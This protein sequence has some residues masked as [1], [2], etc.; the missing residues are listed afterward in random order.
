MCG[1]INNTFIQKKEDNIMKPVNTKLIIEVCEHIVKYN[2]SYR[3]TADIFNIDP[4]TVF[5]YT[6]EV[7]SIDYELYQKVQI[8]LEERRHKKLNHSHKNLKIIYED[9]CNYYLCGNTM[10]KVSIKFTSNVNSIHKLFHIYIKNND[11][12]LYYMVLDMIEI[13]ILKSI[14]A[15]SRLRKMKSIKERLNLCKIIINEKLRLKSAKNRFK[16]DVKTIKSYVNSIIDIDY[17]LY[18]NTC[19]QL[20]IK[21]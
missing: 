2:L 11:E 7:K 10:R 21:S 3:E 14:K 12:E 16:L 8:C 17:D 19:K 5:N 1:I 6:N 9:I 13:N 20:R 4:M 15:R 18:V